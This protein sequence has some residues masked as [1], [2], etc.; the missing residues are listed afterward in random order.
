MVKPNR[1]S[2]YFKL[3]LI[4]PLIFIVQTFIESRI[5]SRDVKDGKSSTSIELVYWLGILWVSLAV[6]MYYKSTSKRQAWSRYLLVFILS[7]WCIA[8]IAGIIYVAIVLTPI[9][10]LAGSGAISP[11]SQWQVWTS[12][13]TQYQNG[14][15][16]WPALL[17]G[18]ELWSWSITK[19]VF[20]QQNYY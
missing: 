10:S 18:I 4:F 3:S 12:L 14:Y 1:K 7:L 5:V 19:M 8:P 11:S 17:W 15:S 6:L 9:Y 2:I 16:Y 13:I 20:Q